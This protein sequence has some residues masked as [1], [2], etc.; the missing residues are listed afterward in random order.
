MGFR[1]W[2]RNAFAVEPPGPAQPTEAQQPIV[3]RLCREVV[4]RGMSVPALLLLESSRPLNFVS[5]QVIHFFTPLLSAITNPEGARLFAEYLEQRG[6]IPYLCDR[7]EQFTDE[8]N[9][10]E[11][12]Q[13][14]P[15]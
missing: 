5:A 2:W 4:N 9:R 13:R 12:L 3:D 1:E 6:S 15:E 14:P 11:S 7:I 10:D 8:Q